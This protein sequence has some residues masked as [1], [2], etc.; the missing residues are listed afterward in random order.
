[1]HW[2]FLRSCV[3]KLLEKNSAFAS[4][5][6]LLSVISDL[7]LFFFLLLPEIPSCLLHLSRAFPTLLPKLLCVF[8]PVCPPGFQLQDLFHGATLPPACSPLG[9]D[10]LCL[11]ICIGM[12][13]IS[14]GCEHCSECAAL[15]P[16]GKV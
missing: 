7:S 15:L 14:G 13:Q 4:C 10:A 5:L 12:G 1:M 9:F 16:R 8:V 6:L 11:G 2:C 3:V